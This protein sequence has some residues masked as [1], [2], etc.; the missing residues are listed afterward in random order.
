MSGVFTGAQENAPLGSVLFAI[1]LKAIK[2][3]ILRTTR[4]QRIIIIRSTFG[5]RN[6]S[7]TWDDLSVCGGVAGK[8]IKFSL[9]MNFHPFYQQYF[10]ILYNYY[11]YYFIIF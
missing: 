5:A 10:D 3:C 6:K 2:I 1:K 4:I 11:Q 8:S 7:L 9:C